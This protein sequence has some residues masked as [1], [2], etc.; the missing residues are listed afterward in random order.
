MTAVA[1]DHALVVISLPRQQSLRS[2]KP[3][4]TW[5]SVRRETTS[6]WVCDRFPVSVPPLM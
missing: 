1:G 4:V 2:W 5:D 3:K 6:C